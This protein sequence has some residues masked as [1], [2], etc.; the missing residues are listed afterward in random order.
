MIDL[1]AK[2][3]RETW[4]VYLIVRFFKY[5]IALFALFKPK[6]AFST[7]WKLLVFP[8]YGL[9][10]LWLTVFLEYR[11]LFLILSIWIP[12]CNGFTISGWL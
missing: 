2:E 10:V 1:H 5:L 7:L 4:I 8:L 6:G 11:L 9:L 3:T 12:S